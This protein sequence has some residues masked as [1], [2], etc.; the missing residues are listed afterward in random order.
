M[1]IRHAFFDIGGVLGTNG[2]DRHQRRDAAEQFGI[3]LEDYSA[4]HAE[5]VAE[6]E[7]GLMSI[8]QYLERTIFTRPRSFTPEDFRQFMYACS[9]PFPESIAVARDLAESHLVRMCTTSNEADELSRYRIRLF[10]LTSI[11]DTFLASSWIGIRKP[12]AMFYERVLAI[13][14]AR[15]EE[16]VFIDD[17]PENLVAPTALGF[18]VIQ[19]QSAD[20]LRRELHD[21]GLEFTSKRG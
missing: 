1:A 4:R 7:E 5:V 15:A 12:A 8:D 9:R 6:F 21:A 14:G 16:T 18:H 11:F 13:T 3:D 17:R 19:Y 10:G 2:W 20:Q